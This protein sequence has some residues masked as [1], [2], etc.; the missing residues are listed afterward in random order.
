MRANRL[1]VVTPQ[2][3]AESPKRVC[4]LTTSAGSL[5][6]AGQMPASTKPHLF[7]FGGH[8]GKADS[9]SVTSC[10]SGLWIFTLPTSQCHGA[11]CFLHTQFVAKAGTLEPSRRFRK[12]RLSTSL[13]ALSRLK[14]LGLSILYFGARVQ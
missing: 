13:Y 8:S 5:S 4:A 6:S 2:K 11:Y 12:L 3:L 14:S 1:A 7:V 9:V 10:R